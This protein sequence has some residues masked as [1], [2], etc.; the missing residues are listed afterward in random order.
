MRQRRVQ[1][2]IGLLT[3]LAC[4]ALLGLPLYRA[5][6]EPRQR[7]ASF[8][9]ARDAWENRPFRRY[10]MVIVQRW[11]SIVSSPCRQQLDVDG[12]RVVA[13]RMLSCPEASYFSPQAVDS[14][15]ALIEP[16]AMSRQC[17]GGDC[18][19]GRLVANV[20][21]D[22]QLGYPRSLS[23]TARPSPFDRWLRW[24]PWDA[25]A[26]PHAPRTG[27]QHFTVLSLAPLP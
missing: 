10:R 14:L 18:A 25:P 22:A 6:M 16:R 20:E 15:L 11:S 4:G 5:A 13:L 26:C 1:L 8:V 19:C 23:L 9:A 21:Y 3:L 24:P 27:P 12:L 2:G 17:E 7:A